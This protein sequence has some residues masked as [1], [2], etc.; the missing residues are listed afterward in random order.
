[1]FGFF[2]KLFGIK[3]A[4]ESVSK[5]EVSES[6]TITLG[7]SDIVV[8][9]PAAPKKAKVTREKKVREKPAPKAKKVVEKPTAKK[10]GRPAKTK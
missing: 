8:S 3:P 9:K 2:K 1:M 5:V 7:D 6:V 4:E 10:R